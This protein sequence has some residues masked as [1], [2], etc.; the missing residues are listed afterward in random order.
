MSEAA[1]RRIC[2][3]EKGNSQSLGKCQIHPAMDRVIAQKHFV[4]HMSIKP[5]QY[6]LSFRSGP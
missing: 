6:Q 2:L 3:I 4:K 5:D 1:H